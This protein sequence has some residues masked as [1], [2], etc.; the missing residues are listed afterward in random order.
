MLKFKDSDCLKN[1]IQYYLTKAVKLDKNFRESLNSCD[2]DCF[3]D[4]LLC[5]E[6]VIFEIFDQEAFPKF[7]GSIFYEKLEQRFR[8]IRDTYYIKGN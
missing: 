7:R 5:Y 1:H 2:T 6:R 4:K 8:N 3:E